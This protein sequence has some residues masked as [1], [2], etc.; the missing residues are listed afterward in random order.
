MVSKDL[1]EKI[2]IELLM[3]EDNRSPIEPISSRYPELT[4]DDAYK[5][6]MSIIE[7]KIQRG[8]TIIG[9]K[10]GL[11][12]RAAQKTFGIH[13]PVYGHL[14]KSMVLLEGE[15]VKMDKL[16]QPMIEAEMAFILGR[17]LKGPVT[18]AEILAS[19]IGI[20][21]A[22]EVVDSRIKDWKVKIQDM[23]ADN[24]AGAHVILGGRLTDIYEVD[25]RHIGLVFE[26]NGEVLTTAAGASVFGNP[27]YAVTWLV[28]KLS[29][30]G[31]T[32]RAG[33][34]V[35]SGSLIGAWP[36]KSGDNFRATF[37]RLGSV[38]VRFL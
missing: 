32:M 3:A 25:L 23:V 29:E 15:V 26:K 11:V 2:A 37:D 8:D 31:I 13:E 28:N 17:D 20:L 24:V 27:A 38:S 12:S 1:V 16:I 19:T 21:P 10:I 4:I 7:K 5:V 34:V 33:E 35:I 22:I 18:V 6:Q 14:M 9:R 30:H 36:V